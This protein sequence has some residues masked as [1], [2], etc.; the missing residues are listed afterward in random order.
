M[1]RTSYIRV[2][3]Y[4]QVYRDLTRLCPLRDPV[5]AALRWAQGTR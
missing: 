5:E 2:K 4:L 1:V 3:D